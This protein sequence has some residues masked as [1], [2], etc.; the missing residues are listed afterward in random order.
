M[1]GN[2]GRRLVRQLKLGP[3][4]IRAALVY[5]LDV[6]PRVA[7]EVKYRRRRAR[8][9]PDPGLREI[10][11][12]VLH[13]KR[14]NLDGAAAFAAFAPRGYRATAIRAQ[15]GLQGIY[16]YVDTLAEQ[17]HPDPVGNSSQ[18]H[19][20]L[21]QALEPAVAHSDYYATH[22]VRQDGQYLATLVQACRAALTGLPSHPCIA[23]AANRCV[24]RII[25]Y[26]TFNV[27]A[28]DAHDRLKE[29]ASLQT[30]AGMNLQWW[31]TAASAGSSLGL[32]ALLALAADPRIT[33][34]EIEAIEGAYFPWVGALHSLLDN[35]VDLHEDANDGQRN[36]VAQY[37]SPQEAALRMR[38]LT[39]ASL[40]HIAKIPNAVPHQL[41]LA[42]M[43]SS[44]L[45][46]REAHRPDARPVADAVIGATG[47]FAQVALAI[48]R[49]RRALGRIPYRRHSPTA[50]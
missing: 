1:T 5:W 12:G 22:G 27:I 25:S 23:E 7:D 33:P 18:L 35:L 39:R 31:E 14:D 37:S 45:S 9:I 50:D 38:M 43:V 24:E 30:P 15:V 44:Y 47:P 16:D 26:Q 46:A 4:F 19:Q 42:G 21:R 49:V 20:A 6:F 17:P 34:Q 13:T 36:Y 41:I 8:T 2:I 48:H 10:A 3:A 11:L 40:R 32:Y 29:W 28:P